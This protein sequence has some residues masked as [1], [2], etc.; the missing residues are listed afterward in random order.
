MNVAIAVTSKPAASSRWKPIRSA[1]YSFSRVKLIW[2]WIVSA[3]VAA[4]A[5]AAASPLE[6]L[7][8]RAARMASASPAS[9]ISIESFCADERAR[10]VMLRDVRDLVREHARELGLGLREQDESRVDADEAA[11]QRE[12]VDLRVGNAEELEV[13]LDV[14]RRGDQP[15]PELVQV[16]V[17]LGVVDVAAARAKLPDDR[18]AELAFLRGRK[19]GLRRRRRDRAGAAERSAAAHR[20]LGAEARPRRIAAAFPAHRS[21]PAIPRE[22]RARERHRRHERRSTGSIF[23]MIRRVR[24]QEYAVCG[25][26]KMP[27]SRASSRDVSAVHAALTHPIHRRHAG[28]RS[29]DDRRGRRVTGILPTS[30]HPDRRTWSTWAART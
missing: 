18:L 15:V 2:C 10:H 24:S 22:R 5:P 25:G 9:D 28:R 11:G 13:L 8:P 19:I 29:R 30:T 1:S 23:G 27:P 17:D 3:C 12:R 14:R 26:A 7:P 20:A 21:D 6:A 16:V 4:I